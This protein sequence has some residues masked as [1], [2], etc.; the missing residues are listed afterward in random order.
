MKAWISLLLLTAALSVALQWARLPAAFLLGAM[1]AAMIVATRGSPL[2]L[3]GWVF[4]LGQAAIG[5]MIARSFTP[6]LFRSMGEHLALFA[7][8]ALSVL[9]AATALGLALTRLRV[10]PGTTALWGSFP[11]AATVMVLLSDSFGGDMRLVALMQY[12]R[13]AVVSVVAS[14]IGRMFGVA[15]APAAATSWLAPVDAPAFAVAAALVLLGGLLGPRLRLPAAPLLIP[16][17]LGA[18]LQDVASIPVALP[19]PALAAS[20]VVIGWAVG[21]RFTP[22]I[23]GQAAR[24]LPRVL[25]S[26]A[27]L[28]AACAGIGWVLA[29][30]AH[31]DPLTAFLATTP[32]G[33]DS[34]AI[35]AA[36]TRVD[37][38]LVMAVQ[39]GRFLAVL[40]LGPALAKAVARRALP[41]PKP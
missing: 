14:L 24:A 23:L 28:V 27:L 16:M 37:A 41:S 11:G 1:A 35:I 39:T 6:A 38:P 22:D 4:A 10:M 20:Y 12:L 25:A 29:R 15:G 13:V 26:I 36:G 17:V 18:L 32:G 19:P 8:A 5:C 21:I 40:L 34:V 7:G 3:P 30:L 33:A 9:L 31:L 2:R